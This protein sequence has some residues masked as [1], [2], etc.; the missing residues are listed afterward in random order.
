MFNKDLSTYD[1]KGFP[2]RSPFHTHIRALVSDALELCMAKPVCPDMAAQVEWCGF[3][4][5]EEDI[6]SQQIQ[7]SLEKLSLTGH[8]FPKIT[9]QQYSW[10]LFLHLL[11]RVKNTGLLAFSTREE[12]TLEDVK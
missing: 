11:S 4:K 7:L 10:G 3:Q 2:Y 8:I 9:K 5:M 6:Q 1:S 12:P